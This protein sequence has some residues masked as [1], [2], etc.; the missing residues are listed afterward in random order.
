MAISEISA[1]PT[2]RG[3]FVSFSPCEYRIDWLTY[4]VSDLSSVRSMQAIFPENEIISAPGE[5]KGKN[6]YNSGMQLI[7]GRVE[8]H[9]EKPEM[10]VLWTFTGR[11]LD[12]WRKLGFTDARLVSF[13]SKL[14]RVNVTRLDFA[15]DVFA[16]ANPLDIKEAWDAGKVNTRAKSC[17]IVERRTRKGTRGVTVYLGSRQSTKLLRVY[18]KAKQMGEKSPRTR[19]EIEVKKPYANE[20][21]QAM[22][23]FGIL[24]AGSA[25]IRAYVRTG[26]EWFDSIMQGSEYATP[27][28]PRKAETDWEK[29]ILSTALPQVVRALH[30]G[31]PQVESS[32][33]IALQVFDESGEHGQ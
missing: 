14:P 30:A 20:V 18:D 15:I 26:V 10:R 16:D 4:T 32:L 12:K 1:P 5:V 13:V 28:T 23:D 29:W 17:S 7:A 24:R 33:R 25:T 9:T 8:W 2:N 21:L 19:I 27:A 11:D 3:A 6:F 22:S 31:M